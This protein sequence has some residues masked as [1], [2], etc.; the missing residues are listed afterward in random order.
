MKTVD[1]LAAIGVMTIVFITVKTVIVVNNLVNG[2]F[3]KKSQKT[4]KEA[5]C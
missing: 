5:A 2:P 4:K 1:T 3:P